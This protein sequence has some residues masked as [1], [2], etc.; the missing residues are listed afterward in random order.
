MYKEALRDVPQVRIVLVIHVEQLHT[1][2]IFP[3]GSMSHGGGW[4]YCSLNT[5]MNCLYYR[6]DYLCL[7]G[8]ACRRTRTRTDIYFPKN[9][10]KVH[11]LGD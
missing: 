8:M 11:C 4:R 7:E 3:L 6:D 1:G 10:P 2:A 9:I 5:Q